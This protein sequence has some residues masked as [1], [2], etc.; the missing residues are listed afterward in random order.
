MLSFFNGFAIVP[1]DLETQNATKPRLEFFRIVQGIQ[2]T[3]ALNES[4]LGYIFA[5]PEIAGR[6]ISQRTKQGLV[7]IYN[8]TIGLPVTT[9]RK[10]NQCGIALPGNGGALVK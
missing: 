4:L 9:E 6:R 2:F 8:L 1:A 3:P 7:A 10:H 5:M